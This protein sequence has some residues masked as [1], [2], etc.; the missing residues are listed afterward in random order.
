MQF[1][2][3][4]IIQTMLLRGPELDNTTE[5][6]ISALIEAYKAIAPREIMLY[7]ID[8]KTP[9]PTLQRIEPDE[10]RRIGDRVAAETGIPVQVS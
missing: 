9:D 7:S 4:G 5:Q 3:S 8:R 2:G 1:C 6:E 10:L